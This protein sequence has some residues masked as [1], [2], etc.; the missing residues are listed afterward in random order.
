MTTSTSLF[1]RAGRRFFAGAL[2]LSLGVGVAATAQA[3][4]DGAGF[5]SHVEKGIDRTLRLPK[6]TDE[7]RSAV[8]TVA[9]RLDATGRIL[10][11]DIVQ[12]AGWEDLD[13]EAL[14]TART[15]AYPAPGRTVTVAMVLGFNQRVTADMQKK[16]E[17]RVL[18]WREEQR[19][20]LA[21]K[22]DARQ[23]DS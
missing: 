14:R 16:A 11:T 10:S 21:D 5:R 3:K 17:Q 6:P 15:V 9:V 18:A 8:A 20:K 12:S 22:T 13:S 4:G 1:Q 7:R 2:T 19:V 23:P